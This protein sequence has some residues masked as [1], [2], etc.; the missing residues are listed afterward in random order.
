MY[1]EQSNNREKISKDKRGYVER[2][3][4]RFG[5]DTRCLQLLFLGDADKSC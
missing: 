5:W 1:D 2:M 4:A 3:V